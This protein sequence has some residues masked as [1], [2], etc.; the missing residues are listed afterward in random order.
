MLLNPYGE[1]NPREHLTFD[2]SAC[3]PETERGRVTVTVVGLNRP[4]LQEERQ[5]VLSMLARLCDIVSDPDSPDTLRRQAMEAIDAFARPEARYSAMARDYL[6]A[7]DAGT[8]NG[9]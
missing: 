8:E 1:T 3:R 5:Y 7:V 9:T 4:E 2:G 6:S